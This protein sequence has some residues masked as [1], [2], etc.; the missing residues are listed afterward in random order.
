MIQTTAS[1][2][3]TTWSAA[4]LAMALVVALAAL[5][6][7]AGA[8]SAYSLAFPWATWLNR[9]GP[10][11]IL[12][13][14]T[15]GSGWAIARRWLSHLSPG[16]LVLVTSPL[17][18]NAWTLIKPAAGSLQ[19]VGVLAISLWLTG[20]LW[21]ALIH[22]QAR[23]GW[24]VGWLW[25]LIAPIYGLTMSATVGSADTFEFQ[26]V[27]PRLG[28]VHPT[29]YPLYLLLGKAWTLLPW[30]NAAWRLNLGTLVYALLALAAVFGLTRRL[31]GA[32]LAGWLAALALGLSPTF[33]SQA[34]EAEV[35]SLNLWL[36]ALALWLML[37]LLEDAEAGSTARRVL[38]LA[39]LLGLSLTH[40]L[41]SVLLWPAAVLTVWWAWRAGRLNLSARRLGQIALAGMM[42]LGL[43]LY[44]PWRWQAVNGE[45]MGWRRFIDW[46]I[47]GRFQGAWQW[48]AWL[49]DG[50][51]YGI[52]GRLFSAEWPLSL[53][54][55]AAI[56]AVWLV[57]HR[58]RAGWL[59]GLT[60]LAYVFYALNYHVPDLNV[61]LLPAQL[62]LAVGVGV[63]L[64]ALSG[65]RRPTTLQAVI[66][67]VLAA[68]ILL[69]ALTLWPQQDRSGPNALLTWGQGVLALPIPT[70]AAILADSEKIAPL[71]YLQQAEGMRPDLDIMV[72]PDEAAYRA[73]VEQRLAADRP[74]Y[75]ARY[76]PHLPYHLRSLGPL[77]E[78]SRQPLTQLPDGLTSSQVA[79]GPVRLLAYALEPAATVAP[80]QAAVTL[81]WQ[82]SAPLTEVWQVYLRWH[83]PE[84]DSV[85]TPGR[86][87][88]N[89][90]YPTPA[91]QVDEIVPDFHL[92]A[93]PLLPFAAPFELQV[94]L[95][96]PFTPAAQLAWQTV[97]GV[98][99]PP[100]VVQA[101]QPTRAQVGSWGLTGFEAPGQIRPNTPFSVLLTGYAP[102]MASALPDA[103]WRVS[104]Q[105]ADNLS[106]VIAP[107][108]P[109]LSR[110]LTPFSWQMPLTSPLQTGRYTLVIS[111]PGASARCGWL[112]AP[113][114]DCPLT[115]LTVSGVTLP[116]EATNFGD[117]IALLSVT[118]DS[119]RLTPGGFLEANLTWLSLAPMARDY[120]V[121]VQVLDD[122]ER[123]VGQV[124]A[125]PVQGTYPTSRWPVGAQVA[126][127]Y[128][129][130]LS[131]DMPPGDYRLYIGLYLLADLQ[132][133]PVLDASG[134]AV[135]D[136][137]SRLD[138]SVR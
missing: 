80:E 49:E 41:T 4:R 66:W 107:G 109:P 50:T 79:F 73:A 87:A 6:G 29:G 57:W 44:L 22:P 35:Y 69:R 81:Y 111:Q 96:P 84:L 54:I 100:I 76:L 18:L 104:L 20:A 99:L 124:D 74:V 48:G 13:A 95:A 21:L 110:D 116:P 82:T 134:Q 115:T 94:A 118:L 71:Y 133:L 72:L 117:L 120:T 2:P 33:W 37:A 28:I 52:V 19:V 136:K 45:P 93:R 7:A 5:I 70:G 135:G 8:H 83:S 67:T 3:S 103:A 36:A 40:H 59:L 131:A 129:V 24:W 16:Q 27:A 98:V 9:L 25:L 112:S 97:A 86:Y 43:Y 68:A 102:A 47:G 89:D 138:L 39:A 15:A 88:A 23:S 51:R 105:P 75:L 55:L 10:T 78:V 1:R 11:A 17:A 42:P 126:D 132:R 121:F 137:Y 106:A 101:A 122:Q 127:A 130:P 65:N 125:W 64:S 61:F 58:R 26:V 31:N 108:P 53:L 90:Y 128:R 77:T 114:A 85:P 119:P 92:L 38:F 123:V 62:I 32:P 46:V 12:A 14:L 34:I 113:R 91:W 30:G 63:A 56:G 60:W